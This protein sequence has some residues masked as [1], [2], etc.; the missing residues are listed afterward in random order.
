[1][2]TLMAALANQDLELASAARRCMELKPH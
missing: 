2:P 1:L